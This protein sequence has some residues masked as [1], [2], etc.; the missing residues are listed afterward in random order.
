MGSHSI[1]HLWQKGEFKSRW[2]DTDPAGTSPPP[3]VMGVQ[4][5][6]GFLINNKIRASLPP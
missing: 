3:A 4:K 2:T 6:Q 1:T 5:E